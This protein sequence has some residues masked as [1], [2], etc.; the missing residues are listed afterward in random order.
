MNKEI[1]KV[2][3]ATGMSKDEV[4]VYLAGLELGEDTVLNIA[5]KAK[6]KRPTVYKI[7]DSLIGKGLMYQTYKGKTRRFGVQD[8]RGLELEMRRKTADLE[9]VIPELLLLHN[10]SDF[11]PRVRFYDGRAGAIAVYQDTLESV[12]Q[13]GEILSS[14]GIR[15]MSSFFP[16]GY[17]DEYIG[18]RVAKNISVKIIA[19]DSS[20]SKEWSKTSEKEL[21]DIRLVPEESFEFSGDMEIYGDKVALISYR[22]NFMAIVIESREIANMQR[23]MFNLA[24]KRLDPTS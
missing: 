13:G 21:R 5:K 11:K 17:P 4:G 15:N 16:D 1:R 8:P 18:N 24:W 2:L 23:F 22:E 12:P 14:T 20:E 19:I 6:R 9:N 7:I 10:V 3:L